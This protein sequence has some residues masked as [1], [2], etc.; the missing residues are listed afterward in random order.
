[1]PL[2]EWTLKEYSVIT[3]VAHQFGLDIP[4][5]VRLLAARK[6]GWADVAGEALSLDDLVEDGL[7]AINRGTATYVKELVD[8]HALARRGANQP[9]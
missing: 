4:E 2:I 1:L 8:P 6:N 3:T 5:A 7:N 9:A